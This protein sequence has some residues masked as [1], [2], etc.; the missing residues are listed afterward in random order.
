MEKKEVLSRLFYLD[1]V[2]DN[3]EGEIKRKLN[4]RG[5][6][7]KIFEIVEKAKSL[8][9]EDL[10]KELLS[11]NQGNKRWFQRY[12]DVYCTKINV[13]SDLLCVD[14]Y[15][16][17]IPL[18]GSNVKR[19][20]LL[21]DIIKKGKDPRTDSLASFP[22]LDVLISTIP[23]VI[24]KYNELFEVLSGN[25]RVLAAINQGYD[26]LEVLII[27]DR[28]TPNSLDEFDL[29]DKSHLNL[30]DHI[31]EVKEH[32]RKGLERIRDYYNG[33]KENPLLID[34]PHEILEKVASQFFREAM[35]SCVIKDDVD[36]MNYSNSSLY[37][38]CMGCGIEIIMK[39]AILLERPEDFKNLEIGFSK[40]KELFLKLL[41]D[42]LSYKQKE[43]IRDILNLIKYKRDKWAHLSFHKFSAYHE[44][45][46]IFNFLEHIYSLYFPKSVILNEI[47]VHKERYK[48]ESGLDFESIEFPL[49]EE[50]K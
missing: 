46:Q 42:T 37:E 49:K 14:D 40:T 6:R 21:K 11:I 15:H 30:K 29:E 8:S 41:P 48:V 20:E 1:I 2:F 35:E 22:N 27:S 13:N 25:H 18:H 34:P 47:K 38:V 32:Y 9:M 7:G 31:E 5:L 45:Y 16:D 33:R 26:E 3:L 4:R 19:G 28:L 44:E 12:K 10:E 43:R 23:I 36:W 50:N 17:G 24:R 39:A